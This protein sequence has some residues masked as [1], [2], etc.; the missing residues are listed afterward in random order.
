PLKL[1][2]NASGTILYFLK[3]MDGYFGAIYSMN[4]DDLALPNSPSVSGSFYGL[5]VDPNSGHVWGAVAPSF[6]QNGYVMRYDLNGIRIDS[7]GVGIG[8]NSFAF[9]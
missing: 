1:Q 4:A 5:G 8:P 3:G 7:V 9:N 2:T 6:T